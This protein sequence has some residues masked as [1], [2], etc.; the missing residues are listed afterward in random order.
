MG[1]LNPPQAQQAVVEAVFLGLRDTE[2]E[3]STV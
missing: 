3:R 1:A 2:L